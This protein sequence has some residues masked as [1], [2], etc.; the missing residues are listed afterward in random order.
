MI[1]YFTLSSDKVKNWKLHF[2]Y[3]IRVCKSENVISSKT[4]AFQSCCFCTLMPRYKYGSNKYKKQNLK[5]GKDII[6]LWPCN[7]DVT[8]HRTLMISLTSSLRLFQMR[9]LSE[10]FLVCVFFYMD[11]KISDLWEILTQ[12]L[13]I[14]VSEFQKI[15]PFSI[16]QSFYSRSINSKLC[17]LLI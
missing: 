4:N 13:L 15:I 6:H 3:M 1:N 11:R 7:N 16:R 8:N 12:I 2:S 17:L 14:A 9:R 10:S 5:P